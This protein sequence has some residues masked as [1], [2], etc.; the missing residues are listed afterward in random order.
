MRRATEPF[1]LFQVD[2]ERV[3]NQLPMVGQTGW[4]Q[5]TMAPQ[6]LA[7]RGYRALRQFLQKRYQL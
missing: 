7:E 5:A 6:P 3:E 2:L 1:Y 4:L